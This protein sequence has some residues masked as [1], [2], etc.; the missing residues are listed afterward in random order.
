MT[1]AVFGCVGDD[2]APCDDQSQC[3]PGFVCIDNICVEGVAPPPTNMGVC[4]E[5]ASL[6]GPDGVK[7]NVPPQAVGACVD[8]T[9]TV[10]SRTTTIDGVTLLTPSY[11]FSPVDQQFAVSAR[12]E[13]PV[14]VGAIPAGERPTL[15]RSDLLGGDWIVVTGTPTAS[16]AIGVTNRLGVFAAGFG[17]PTR[18]D[19]GVAEDTGPAED[20]GAPDAGVPDAGEE[21]EAGVMDMGVVADTGPTDAGFIDGAPVD[22][23]VVVADTGPV[24]LG[25]VPDLG[26]P[27][28][29]FPDLGPEPDTG[30]PPPT[31]TG[32]HDDADLSDLG[33]PPDTGEP[34]PDTGLN[35]DAELPD[36][37]VIVMGDD[38][39]L[40]PDALPP[41]GDAGELTEDTGLHAD[42]ATPDAGPDPSEDTGLHPDADPGENVDPADDTGLHPD[43]DPG[44]NVDPADD[45]GLH[46]DADDDDAG[47]DSDTG[48]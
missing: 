39:G 24:D 44:E 23:G 19:A 34:T 9:I 17:T 21:V 4:P 38:T 35:P 36:S 30:P 20:S 15:Y 1:F 13:I 3:L 16:L 40:H 11:L 25:V 14:D 48:L 27:D 10:A 41:S 12:V 31:D 32:I 46:P 2:A 33:P 18:R 5:G 45:T 28:F 8:I 43:A 29:G 37:G 42:A 22:T 26:F 7:L 6:E 47:V